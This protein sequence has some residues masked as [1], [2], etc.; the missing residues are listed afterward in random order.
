MTAGT[1]LIGGARFTPTITGPLTGRLES[2]VSVQF[3]GI[4]KLQPELTI[5]IYDAGTATAPGAL[6]VDTTS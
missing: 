4:L 2:P 6:L 3:Y 5:K 1:T